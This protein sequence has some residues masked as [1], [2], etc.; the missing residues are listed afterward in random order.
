M[1]RKLLRPEV[2]FLMGTIQG[3]LPYLLFA[4][5]GT[6][7]VVDF[8]LSYYPMWIWIIGYICFFIGTRIGPRNFSESMETDVPV[9]MSLLKTALVVLSVISL[10]EIVGLIRVYGG[11]PLLLFLSGTADVN[12]TN[13]AQQASGLGQIGAASLTVYLLMGLICLIAIKAKQIESKTA[14][15][16]VCSTF[17]II[18]LAAF[19]GKRQGLLMCIV[20][21]ACSSILT[22]GDPFEIISSFLPGKMGSRGTVIIGII[23]FL[24]VFKG[25]GAVVAFRN[26]G[27]HQ[28]S[29]TDE[30]SLYYEWPI[31]N[32]SLQTLKSDGFGPYEFK[33]LGPFKTLLPAKIALNPSI[34]GEDVP[35]VE[36]TSPS[37]FYEQL[38]W[39]TGLWG[40]IPF[41]FFCGLFCQYMYRMAFK[42]YA[43]SLS[44]S[45][46]AWALFSAPLYNHFLNLLFLPLPAT[47]FIITA[48]LHRQLKHTLA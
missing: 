18:F 2:L 42:G 46:I 33:P 22:F 31:M 28:I 21:L 37:G 32:M 4:I 48:Y 41:T 35:R 3:L 8:E 47:I 25:L 26:N 23:C 34:F 29:T 43:S 30:L 15:W 40:I 5:F 10:G 19:N 36:E 17:L 7:A 44:Y 11:I 45:M 13:L 27:N 14:R 6:S 12:D 24:V 9:S 38:Q 20:L 1:W 16:L 39:T